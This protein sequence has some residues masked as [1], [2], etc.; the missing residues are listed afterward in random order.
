MV[1]QKKE[2]CMYSKHSQNEKQMERRIEKQIKSGIYRFVHILFHIFF[3]GAVIALFGYAVLWLWN[4][5][6]PEIFG[7]QEI[8]FWQAAGLLLLVR[9]LFGGIGNHR[10]WGMNKMRH[11]HHPIHEKWLRMTRREQK[12]FLGRH[13][14]EAGFGMDFSGDENAEKQD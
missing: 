12:A 5:I 11:F 8:N 6:I 9:I 2:N 14:W 1:E 7:L 3:G 10:F 4:R 13:Y